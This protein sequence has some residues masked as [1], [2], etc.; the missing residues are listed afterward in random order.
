ME[1]PDPT[2]AFIVPT[3]FDSADYYN[4]QFEEEIRQFLGAS[5]QLLGAM[6]ESMLTISTGVISPGYGC[7]SVMTE[8]AASSDNLDRI[9]YVDIEDGRLLLL[10]PNDITKVVTIRSMQ[11]GIGQISLASGTAFSMNNANRFIL[12]QRRGTIF[13]ELLRGGSVE[14]ARGQQLIVNSTTFSAPA[15]TLFVTAVGGGGGGGGG[16]GCDTDGTLHQGLAGGNGTTTS[17]GSINALGGGGGFPASSGVGGK[18]NSLGGQNGN[19]AV[20]VLAGQGAQY[21]LG[22]LGGT[23][24]RGGSGGNGAAGKA[25]GGGGSGAAGH[26]NSIL[27][28][29]FTTTVGASITVTIGTGGTAGAGGAGSQQAGS[30]GEA[31]TK[32]AVLVEW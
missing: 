5:Q 7:H 12:L 6:P 27:R 3:D 26:T 29:I 30:A 25:G 8:S 31:G 24:G 11:G 20:G 13:Q 10:W 32:G 19:S 23:N 4:T 28:E 21:K 17:F 1:L 9:S 15:D 18:G 16:C 2:T 14:S 22:F